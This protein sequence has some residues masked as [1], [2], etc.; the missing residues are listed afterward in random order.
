MRIRRAGLRCDR[1]RS[2]RCRQP[3]VRTWQ[4]TTEGRPLSGRSRLDVGR[5]GSTAESPGTTARTWIRVGR[6]FPARSRPV[7]KK[8]GSQGLAREKHRETSG[9]GRIRVFNQCGQ[10]P[11]FHGSAMEERFV[12]CGTELPCPPAVRDR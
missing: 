10:A 1:S 8:K 4:G 7:K 9:S 3:L 12:E 5:W 11:S 2:V 6:S